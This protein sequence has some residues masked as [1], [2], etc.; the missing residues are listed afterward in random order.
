MVPFGVDII[1]SAQGQSFRVDQKHLKSRSSDLMIHQDSV[2]LFSNGVTHIL[3]GTGI[4]EQSGVIFGNL[5]DIRV[6]ID[7]IESHLEGI[8]DMHAGVA[9]NLSLLPEESSLIVTF[10]ESPDD[11]QLERIRSSTSHEGY[12]LYD[13][14][15][16]V[17]FWPVNLVNARHIKDA[18][19]SLST[20]S[21]WVRG[22]VDGDIILVCS[23][24]EDGSVTFIN[25]EQIGSSED[26]L[27]Y[28]AY[29]PDGLSTF[30]LISVKEKGHHQ[31]TDATP[32]RSSVDP[33][34]ETNTDE[35]SGPSLVIVSVILTGA[36]L[37]V[38]CSFFWYRK[39]RG[40]S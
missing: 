28:S 18:T 14:S 22:E 11:I 37:A 40:Q 20:P 16:L 12:D 5:E 36:I 26:N 23:L 21:G 35:P 34:E 15:Y 38:F 6:E 24:H 8:E 39:R 30:A 13:I 25:P 19:V 4:R 33:A 10:Y 2:H 9:M 31:V 32:S 7:P 27:V 1:R 29:S 3:K 17:S